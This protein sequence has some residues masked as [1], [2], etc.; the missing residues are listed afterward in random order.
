MFRVST[1]FDQA[2][3]GTA[4]VNHNAIIP[5]QKNNSYINASAIVI[6]FE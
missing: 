5:V 4:V 1:N 3:A 2:W 6:E